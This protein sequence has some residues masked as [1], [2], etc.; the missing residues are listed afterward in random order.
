[1]ADRRVLLLTTTLVTLLFVFSSLGL[2]G[3]MGSGSARH[4][5]PSSTV[6]SASAT[7]SA[8]AWKAPSVAPTLHLPQL[9]ANAPSTQPTLQTAQP[10]VDST[11]HAVAIAQ[12]LIKEKQLNPSSVFFPTQPST[13]TVPGATYNTSQYVVNPVPQGLADIGHG[14][15]GAYIYNASSFEATMHINSFTDYNPGYVSWVAPPDFM[16]WQLNTVTV[17]VSYP[18][19]TDGVFWVQ[20]VVHFNGTSLQFEDNIWNMSGSNTCLTCGMFTNTLLTHLGT[21]VNDSFYYVYGPTY[22]VTYP[23]SL[24]LYNNISIVG[25]HPGVYLNYTITNTTTG[26]HTGSFDNVTFNGA[27]APS[28]PPMFE[29]NGKKNNPLGLYW[30]SE[31]IFGGNGGG[32]NAVITN[33]NA[34][35]NLKY[36]SATGHDYLGVPSAY[37]YGLDTGETADGVAVAYQGTTELLSQGP[38][39]LYGLWNTTN[40]T[41]GPH[42]QPGWIDVDLTGL[43]NYGFAF[44]TNQTSYSFVRNPTFNWS[45]AP[46]DVNGNTVTHLPPPPSG[47]P[48]IFE[49]WADGYNQQNLT[50]SSNATGTASFSLA[51]N[52]HSFDTPVYLSTEAQVAAFGAAGLAGVTL[53]GGNLWINNTQAS[54]PVPFN[55]L[56][57]F[58]FPEFMLF[59]EYH[60]STNISINHFVQNPLSF[61]YYKYN[62]VRPNTGINYYAGLTQGY[63][64]NYGTGQF[65]VTNVSV[66]GSAYLTYVAHFVSLSSVEF[67]NTTGSVAAYATTNLDS[68]GI[69]VEDSQDAFLYD[70]AG[71]G[72]A[73]AIAVLDSTYVLAEK[74]SANGTDMAGGQAG[75]MPFPT[76]GAYLQGDSFVDVIGL[77]A[78]NGSVLLFDLG[79]NYTWF[80]DV[81]AINN[82]VTTGFT[83]PEY[84]FLAMFEGDL[85]VELTNAT[86]ANSTSILGVAFMFVEDVGV[87]VNNVTVTG[88]NPAATHPPWVAN[89]GIG[90]DVLFSTPSGPPVSGYVDISNV[91]ASFGAMGVLGEY[92]VWLN[93]SNVEGA[94]TSSGLFLLEALHVHVWDVTVQTQAVATYFGQIT[95]L[96]VS[97]LWAGSD[98]V[99]IWTQLVNTLDIWDVNGTSATLG[100]STITNALLAGTVPIPQAAVYLE[101]NVN[102]SV[103]NV[104]TLNYNYAVMEN[105][106]SNVSISHIRAWNGATALS[107][108]TSHEV[109][110]SS[111]FLFGNQKGASFLNVVGVTLTGST[112]ENSASFGVTVTQGSGFVAYANNFVANNG[113]STSGNYSASHVQATVP[114][115]AGPLF[116]YLGIGNYWSDWGGSGSYT[117]SG[118]VADTAPLSAFITNWLEIDEVGLPAGTSWGFT[119]DTIPYSTSTPLVF[120]PSWS[121]ANATLGF[122]VNPPSGYTPTPASGTIPYSGANTTQTISFARAHVNVTFVESGLP[123][124]TVWSVTFNGT[125]EMDTTVGSSGSIVFSVFLG[126][127]AYTVG[128]VANYNAAP[129]SGNVLVTGNQNV[130]IVF[131]H[132]PVAYPVTFTESGLN[133][134][135]SWSVTLGSSTKSSANTTI[136]FLELN[137]TYLYSIP[138][139]G[140][141]TPTPPGGNVQVNGMPVNLNVMF[142]GPSVGKYAVTFS[143]TGLS[144]MNWSVT[145]TSSSGSTTAYSDFTS[146]VVFQVTNG[147]YSFTINPVPGYKVEEASGMVQVAGGPLMES[148]VFAPVT[149]TITFSETGLTTGTNWSVTIG[150]VTHYS[151]GTTLTFQE[152]NGTYSYQIGAVNGYSVS[153]ASGTVTLTGAATGVNVAF[154]SSGSGS[155]STGLSTLDWALIGIVI[156]IIVIALIVALVMRGRGGRGASTESAA[157]VESSEGAAE[158]PPWSESDEPTTGS[159]P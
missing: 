80:N 147:T 16:T 87:I 9:G 34:T 36:W 21:I 66:Y 11:N 45:Y 155:S 6:P 55:F 158:P 51:A 84:G 113:A 89:V 43:P 2:L 119:L 103:S 105:Y 133:P 28:H 23:F 5:S 74:L 42:A 115:A 75:L 77:T 145:L 70:I 78:T 149:Y 131:T 63:F 136:T 73:N 152:V 109:T 126:S 86:A 32:A 59:A 60:L 64:F 144:G 81:S 85:G 14:T 67:W 13:S 106:S 49:G 58:R 48:Y 148:V 8:G 33:L 100:P 108:N 118:G 94:G 128:S 139:V 97:N 102:E 22:N 65:I 57:D 110:V 153:A 39:F 71:N 53:K 129:S 143:E 72:G 130:D 122:V 135:T 44:A 12:Q 124:G 54:L 10:I 31:L 112:I 93:A 3:A 17:N 150:T 141:Y 117:I 107:L 121:L 95:Y 7:A 111:A 98:S 15:G 159:P 25:G 76:W 18:G 61:R 41:W 56:S 156:A 26:D 82:P 91:S 104:S 137:N 83:Y 79:C 125:T 90:F 88:T 127:Y 116:T 1:M 29:V 138:N 62:S 50:V 20:N 27:A 132:V 38:S 151:V 123:S 92:I 19:G 69:A 68:F 96:N 4:D 52:S 157:P 154:T 47:D 134:G 142:T 99:A 120:I 40:S 24:A 30:D 101:G 114:G 46:S 35:A 146:N 37:D 140:A